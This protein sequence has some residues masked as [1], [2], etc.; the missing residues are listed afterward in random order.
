MRIDLTYF[1]PLLVP[2]AAIVAAPI[3]AAAPMGGR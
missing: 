1:T 2:A 3:A